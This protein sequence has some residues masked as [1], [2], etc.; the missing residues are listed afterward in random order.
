MLLPPD[1]PVRRLIYSPVGQINRDYD[2]V[3]RFRDA[4]Y[5]GVKRALKA[6][7]VK[8]CDRTVNR[9]ETSSNCDCLIAMRTAVDLRAVHRHQCQSIR[10]VRRDNRVGR[11]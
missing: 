5:R 3:R 1:E 7:S 4:A 9:G 11:V 10:A 2:D 6:G 8:V